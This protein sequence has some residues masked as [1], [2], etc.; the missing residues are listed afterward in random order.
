M[1]QAGDVIYAP[2]EAAFQSFTSNGTW[3]RP[4]GIRSVWVRLVGGGG[5]GGYARATDAGESAVGG[6]GG[7]GGYAEAIIPADR[8]TA[9]VAVTVGAGGAGAVEGVST[10]GGQGGQS[11]FGDYVVASGGLGGLRGPDVTA[12]PLHVTTGGAGGEGLTGD[13]LLSGGPGYPGIGAGGTIWAG[14]RGGSS[15]FGGEQ[16][17]TASGSTG[18][19]GAGTPRGGGGTGGFNGQNQ[20]VPQDGGAGSSGL[21]VV[22]YIF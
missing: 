18:V 21:V 16:R 13:I 5:G 7:G 6:G 15:A 8:L 3:T 10:V 22:L 4:D 19:G 14:G 17:E 1:F 9:T 11:S 20:A 12:P 2:G